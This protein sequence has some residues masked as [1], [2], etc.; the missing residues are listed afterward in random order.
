MFKNVIAEN[1]PNLRKELDIKFMKLTEHLII[2][3]QKDLL[4]DTLHQN[5]QRSVMKHSG[6]K[7]GH[8]HMYSH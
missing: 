7:D 4:Q 5:C 3:M 6:K 8:L 2:I 1:F